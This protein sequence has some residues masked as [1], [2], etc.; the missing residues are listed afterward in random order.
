MRV[1]RLRR[2]AATIGV[3]AITAALPGMAWASAGPVDQH[4]GPVAYAFTGA[5]HAST[6]DGADT[7]DE[8]Y[9]SPLEPG[10]VGVR[11]PSNA[12]RSDFIPVGP[13]STGTSWFMHVNSDR[14][15]FSSSTR[16]EGTT[17][18]EFFES[19]AELSRTSVPRATV[20]ADYMLEAQNALGDDT[21]DHRWLY[22]DDVRSHAE[23]RSAENVS[24]RTTAGQLWIRQ[25]DRTLAAVPLPVGDEAYRVNGMPLRLPNSTMEQQAL[26]QFADVS[27]RRV[28]G[29]ADLIDTDQ[30]RTGEVNAATGWRVEVTSYV[31]A[32]GIRTEVDRSALIL[33]AV[34]CS[35][36]R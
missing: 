15:V 7:F 2:R 8:V 5:Y 35:L 11:P 32:N 33:G 4:T 27:V 21:A 36:S 10:V 20:R 1:S 22:L 19:T 30:W 6:L 13:L 3:V 9:R 34:S 29:P 31:V 23:C 16:P 17:V 14:G 25:P 18:D 12:A 26:P 28:T 24:A